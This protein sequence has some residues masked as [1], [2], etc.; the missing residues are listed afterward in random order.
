MQVKVKQQNGFRPVTVKLKFDNKV[1]YECFR[2]MF[3]L[4]GTIP[5]AIGTGGVERMATNTGVKMKEEDLIC[6]IQGVLERV[7]GK[8]PKVFRK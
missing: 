8:L 3:A 1:E 5:D 7:A 2:Q 6:C 4:T